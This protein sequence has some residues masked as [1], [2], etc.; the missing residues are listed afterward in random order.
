MCTEMGCVLKVFRSFVFR[1]KSGRINQ[2]LFRSFN[3]IK[4]LILFMLFLLSNFKT[5]GRDEKTQSIISPVLEMYY[6]LHSLI[7]N[8]KSPKLN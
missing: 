5:E 8:F 4:F 6:K 7:L 2:F 3:Q 1:V